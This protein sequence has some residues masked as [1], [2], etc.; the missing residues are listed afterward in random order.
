MN[1]VIEDGTQ[2]WYQNGQRHRLDGPAVIWANGTQYWYQNGQRHRLDGPAAI[3][4]DGAQ[5][6]FQNDKLHRMDGPAA[7]WAD[8]FQRWYQNDQNITEQV[9]CWFKE[10]NVLQYEDMDEDLEVCF[11]IFLGTL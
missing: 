4:P 11:L 6:W 9:L 7:I 8:G 1:P 5:T 10:Q 2:V 3:R